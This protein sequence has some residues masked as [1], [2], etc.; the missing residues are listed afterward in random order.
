MSRKQK[1]EILYEKIAK[2][3]NAIYF[4]TAEEKEAAIMVLMDLLYKDVNETL[5]I[6]KA[7]AFSIIHGTHKSKVTSLITNKFWEHQMDYG[8]MPKKFKEE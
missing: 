1:A 2:A 4:P 6:E 8:V 5:I 3:Y 7:R